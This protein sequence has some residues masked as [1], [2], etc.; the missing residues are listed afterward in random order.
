MHLTPSSGRIADAR[1]TSQRIAKRRPVKYRDDDYYRALNLAIDGLKALEVS[2][3]P[4]LEEVDGGAATSQENRQQPLP[5]TTPTPLTTEVLDAPNTENGEGGSEANMASWNDV[6][7][8]GTPVVAG[9]RTPVVAGA[10][11]PVVAA[12]AA[13]GKAFFSALNP[14]AAAY[15]PPNGTTTQGQLTNTDSQI[16]DLV[17]TL[18]TELRQVSADLQAHKHQTSDA[19]RVH[20][21]LKKQQI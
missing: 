20:E 12:A 4:N 17:D 5:S 10:R 21:A 8:P 13:V 11:T 16:W 15:N 18:Q 2:P 7:G 1:R 19:G 14:F 6:S 9:A 3:R